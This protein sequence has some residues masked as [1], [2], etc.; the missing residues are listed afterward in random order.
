MR[1]YTLSVT[2]RTEVM[3]TR[4]D[5]LRRKSDHDVDPDPV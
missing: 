5:D 1:E 3:A 4:V 2:R